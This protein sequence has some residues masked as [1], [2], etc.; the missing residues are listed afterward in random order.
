[1]PQRALTIDPA[2]SDLTVA[3]N[4]NGIVPTAA[5]DLNLNFFFGT[6]QLS[7]PVTIS[8]LGPSTAKGSVT[9]TL[10]LLAAPPYAPTMNIQSFYSAPVK[11]NLAPNTST[12]TKTLPALNVT[13]PTNATASVLYYLQVQISSTAITDPNH[14]NNTATTARAFN[15]VGTPTY[16]SL[17]NGTTKATVGKTTTVIGNTFFNFVRDTLNG[18][19]A[20]QLKTGSKTTDVNDPQ[21][22]L[23]GFEG[24]HPYAY[25]DGSGNP[26]IGVGIN[27]TPLDTATGANTPLANSARRDG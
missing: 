16:G 6:E 21:S 9:L 26:T 23:K 13:M 27:L 7:I 20:L 2:S 24:S 5:T 17:F 3:I 12:S 1:M 10:S 19:S 8:N 4:T 25:M 14:R 15:F 22:F 18:V 11:I